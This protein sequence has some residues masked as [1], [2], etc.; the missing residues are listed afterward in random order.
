VTAVRIEA[1]GLS[2]GMGPETAILAGTASVTAAPAI[3]PG[4]ILIAQGPGSNQNSTNA[5]T[6]AR[7]TASNQN[8]TGVI[9]IAR[10]TGIDPNFGPGDIG[11]S[12]GII[13]PDVS[14]GDLNI[15]W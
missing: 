10:P 3:I 5:I 13:T 8:S 9:T 6:V 4:V 15:P 1:A 2:N 7:R 11:R 14:T 12:T